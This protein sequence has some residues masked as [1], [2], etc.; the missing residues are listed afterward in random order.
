MSNGHL[1]DNASRIAAEIL[2]GDRIKRIA[3]KILDSFKREAVSPPGWRGTVEHM[4]EHKKVT[5]PWALAWWMHNQK[6]PGGKKKKFKPHYT[7]EGDKKKK[8]LTKDEKKNKKNKKKKTKKNKTEE[9]ETKEERRKAA[10]R[11][12]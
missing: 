5:N 10:S 8:Y 2:A 4:K 12:F 3:Q 9:K 11:R 1:D 6:K 7:E